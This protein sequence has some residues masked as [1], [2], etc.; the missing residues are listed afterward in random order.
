MIATRTAAS[1][2]AFGQPVLAGALVLLLFLSALASASPSLH[3]WLHADHQ[4]PSHYCL[5]TVL[6]H[7]QTDVA[8]LW[9]AA[10]PAVVGVPVSALPCESFFVSH[11]AKLYPERGPPALS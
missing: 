4:T 8:S 6:E 3:H 10:A 1:L 2:R 7:G 5:V 11:D 9:V